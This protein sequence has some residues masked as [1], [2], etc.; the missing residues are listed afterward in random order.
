MLFELDD[1]N[2]LSAEDKLRYFLKFD[3]TRYSFRFYERPYDKLYDLYVQSG[4]I[5]EDKFSKRDIFK[6]YA[7]ISNNEDKILLRMNDIKYRKIGEYYEL[8]GD[9]EPAMGQVYDSQGKH[10]KSERIRRYRKLDDEELDELFLMET[11]QKRLMN[12]IRKLIRF[13]KI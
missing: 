2:N 13:F 4:K 9:F 8:C 7:D 3:N 12:C 1:S 10:I 6:R 5:S 11:Q